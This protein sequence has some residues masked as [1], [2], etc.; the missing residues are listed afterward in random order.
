MPQPK[1]HND[2]MSLFPAYMRYVMGKLFCNTNYPLQCTG[3]GK[4]ITK[5][6]AKQFDNQCKSCWHEM[7]RERS[8]NEISER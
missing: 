3:C 1:L 4:P 6:E 7:C 8:L 2:G 5:K